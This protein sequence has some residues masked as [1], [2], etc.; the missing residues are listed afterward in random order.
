MTKNDILPAEAKM[1]SS[2]SLNV[3]IFLHSWGKKNQEFPEFPKIQG[4][5]DHVF[6]IMTNQENKKKKKSSLVDNLYMTMLMH[7]PKIQ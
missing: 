4:T 1:S 6:K 3:M 5:P 7:P 2:R